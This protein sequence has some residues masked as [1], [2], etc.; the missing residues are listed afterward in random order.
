MDV[1]RE[2]QVSTE[3]RNSKLLG[4]GDGR[5]QKCRERI[6]ISKF[7]SVAS[8][9]FRQVRLVCTL[10]FA[11]KLSVIKILREIDL[12]KVPIEKLEFCN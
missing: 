2:S 5:R 1:F 4:S 7:N 11:K 9:K 6:R 8:D 3:I 12:S 10:L